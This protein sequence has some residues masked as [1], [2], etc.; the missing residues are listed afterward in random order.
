MQSALYAECCALSCYADWC[1]FYQ[2]WFLII[3]STEQNDIQHYESHHN[4]TEHTDTLNTD[5]QHTDTQHTDTQHTNT[6]QVRRH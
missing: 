5:T 1:H 6:Q 3:S 4:D 2:L